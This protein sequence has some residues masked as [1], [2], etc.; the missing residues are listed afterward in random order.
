MGI[1]GSLPSESTFPAGSRER[2]PTFLFERRPAR[3]N[4]TTRL[5]TTA[6]VEGYNQG[7]CAAGVVR[8][9]RRFVLV[10][11]GGF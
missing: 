11:R 10:G 3:K 6:A 7:G 4:H 1:C 8:R 2:C 9:N 5:L